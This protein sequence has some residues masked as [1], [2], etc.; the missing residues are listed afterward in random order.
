[1]TN[2][3]TIYRAT[4]LVNNKTYV[5]FDSKWPHRQKD[6]ICKAGKRY[7][8]IF[9]RALAKHGCDNFVWEIL[10][11]SRDGDHTLNVMEG[12]FIA[13]NQSF[14]PSGYNLT[15]GGEGC[16]GMVQSEETRQKMSVAHK[17]RSA[18]TRQKMSDNRKGKPRSAETRAKISAANRARGPMSNETRQ[19]I[20][21]ANKGKT[22]SAE[23]RSKQGKP[24]STPF[25][26]FPSTKQAA[27]HLNISTAAIHRRLNSVNFPEWNYL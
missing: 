11:Q 18:E 21:A 9:T 1:M 20:S 10:Y 23:T 5:G 3:Y 13:E 16:L 17:N 24:I 14:G 19:K 15:L 25:G 8:G 4:N 27:E 7:Y 12:Y 6:H 26:Q 2:I 22:R